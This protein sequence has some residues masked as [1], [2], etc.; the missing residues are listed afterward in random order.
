MAWT[1]S[2]NLRILSRMT[3]SEEN[4]TQLWGEEDRA[5]RPDYRVIDA[6]FEAIRQTYRETWN[7]FY[8]W[9]QEESLQLIRSLRRKKSKKG[10]QSPDSALLE[11][12]EIDLA[13]YMMPSHAPIGIDEEQVTFYDGESIQTITSVCKV[14]EAPAFLPFPVYES[15]TPTPYTLI[16]HHRLACNEDTLQFFPCDENGIIENEKFLERYKH[17]RWMVDQRDPDRSFSSFNF[18]SLSFLT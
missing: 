17:L 3:F 8:N 16:P 7:E 9:E 18:S 15:C 1:Y 6:E 4:Y 2:P 11:S 10:L 12:G 5:R 14:F 13:R